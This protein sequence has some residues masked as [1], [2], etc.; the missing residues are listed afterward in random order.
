MTTKHRARQRIAELISSVGEPEARA[1]VND[2]GN[3][4]AN[5]MFDAVAARLQARTMLSAR[6][7]RRSIAYYL[8]ARYQISLTTAYRRLSEAMAEPF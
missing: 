4:C 7:P 6:Q 1:I 3:N 2:I 5:N 8:A